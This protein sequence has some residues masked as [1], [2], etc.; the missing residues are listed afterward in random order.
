MIALHS[1]FMKI[2]TQDINLV[3]GAIIIAMM[4]MRKER[5]S[6]ADVS[7]EVRKKLQFTKKEEE[8]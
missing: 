1:D 7:I 4:L 2:E 5:E 6:R 8:N 3:A